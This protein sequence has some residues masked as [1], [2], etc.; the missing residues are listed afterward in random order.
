M[1]IS[2]TT[3]S[4]IKVNDIDV[5]VLKKN[6]KNFHLNVLP[7]DGR[8]RISVPTSTTDGAIRTFAITRL[9]WI[10]KQIKAFHDQSRQTER[11]YV[12]GESHYFKGQRYLLNVIHHN[13]P[14]KIEVRN[15]KYLD[16]Y[17]PKDHTITQKEKAVMNRYRQ[18]LKK[19]IPSLIDK[20]QKVV[21]VKINDWEVKRM[22][23]VW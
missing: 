10:R 5:L 2:K 23:T 3:E 22:K 9:P 6:I 17:V 13:A 20:R 16:F 21:G 15:K 14:A 4:V 12:S 1:S 8:V 18:E 11:Q 19:E 7:P